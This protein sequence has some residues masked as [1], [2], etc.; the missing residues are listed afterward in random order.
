MAKSK[1]YTSPI[2]RSRRLDIH[3]LAKADKYLAR[4]PYAPGQH[5]QSR[6]SKPSDY[7]L[8]LQEK[9]RAKFIY[10][11]R[12]RQFRNIF[13]VAAKGSSATGE[14][15]LQL[16]ELRLDN[17]IYRCGMART[18]RQAR[19]LVTHGHFCVNNRCATIPSL[20]VS[21]DDIISPKN[22]EGFNF[23]DTESVSWIKKDSKKIASQLIKIPSRLEIPTELDEQL[24]IEFYSR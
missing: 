18:R 3:V 15:L 24:I 4:R 23:H 1:V 21:K 12:E 13:R 8:Q 5:G 17:I 19:Q 14:K 2:K 7:A 16:L 11:L 10:G 9:Q 20:T 22:K 6:R